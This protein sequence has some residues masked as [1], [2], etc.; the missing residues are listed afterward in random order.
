MLRA[1]RWL[2][3]D[4]VVVVARWIPKLRVRTSVSL[5]FLGGRANETFALSSEIASE[6]QLT[7]HMYRVEYLAATLERR[8]ARRAL[9]VGSQGSQLVR[10]R[11]DRGGG[12]MEFVSQF[13]EVTGRI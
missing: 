7:L 2:L 9:A 5:W 10:V 8:K 11:S 12:C 4:L 3:W 13:G 1:G 6:T